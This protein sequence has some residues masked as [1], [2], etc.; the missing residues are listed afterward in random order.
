MQN[1][2]VK[3]K[4]GGVIIENIWASGEDRFEYTGWVDIENLLTYKDI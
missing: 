2:V 3:L 1:E 4:E